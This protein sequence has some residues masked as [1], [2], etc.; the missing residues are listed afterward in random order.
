MIAL[1]AFSNNRFK[2]TFRNLFTSLKPA[3]KPAEPALSLR[4][5]STFSQ[6][7]VTSEIPELE[8]GV[9]LRSVSSFEN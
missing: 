7:T 3:L 2:A 5:L 9:R 6:S 8:N 4:R 1:Y